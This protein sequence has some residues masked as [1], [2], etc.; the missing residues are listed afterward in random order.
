VAEA[1]QGVIEVEDILRNELKNLT[2]EQI[3]FICA[4]AKIGKEN[5]MGAT[6]EELDGIYDL[7][8]DIEIAEIPDSDTEEESDRCRLA[9]SIVTLF[10][11]AIA[12]A[13]GYLDEQEEQ[14]SEEDQSGV[15]L[16]REFILSKKKPD[17]AEENE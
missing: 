17:K 14:D 11:N 5:L 3:D 9:S 2:D 7:M 15:E 6:E 16:L 13:E 4:E 8:C 1:K 12:E 10:G